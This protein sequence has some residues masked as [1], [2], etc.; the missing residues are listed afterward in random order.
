MKLTVTTLALFLGISAFAGAGP[1]AGGDEFADSVRPFL[2][3]YC[4]SC[5][6]GERPKGGLS[7]SAHASLADAA[8]DPGVWRR[9]HDMMVREEMPP[10][11]EDQPSAEE[12]SRLLTWIDAEFPRGNASRDP[13]RVTMRRL[14]RV[15]YE[16]TVRD[17]VGVHFDASA[18]FPVDDV[19]HG[20]DNIADVLSMSP[21]LLEKYL[22]AAERIAAL[23]IVDRN[24]DQPPVRIWDGEELT[25]D[26]R[27]GGA[28]RGV[29][30]LSSNGE[31]HTQH[32]F[33][34][35][36]LY[37]LRARAYGQQAGPA[38]VR[39]EFRID[40]KRQKVVEVPAT[41]EAPGEYETEVR[42]KAGMHRV[43]VA[44]IN[45]YYRPEDPD[46]KNRDRNFALIT[47]EV[48][49]PLDPA[50]LSPFQR[51]LLGDEPTTG[52]RQ[53]KLKRAVESLAERAYRRPVEDEE[54]ERLL[55]AIDG[56][57]DDE[58]SLEEHAR[59]ALTMLLV[60][61]RFLF[62]MELDPSGGSAETTSKVRELDGYELASRLSY[63]LWSSMPDDA[64]FEAAR[65]GTLTGDAELRRQVRRMIRSP[66]AT[67]L[68]EN[69]A[70][71]WLQIRDLVDR[72]PDPK[73]FP[74]VDAE[75]LRS[76]VAETVLL[77]EAVL[78]EGRSVRELLDADFT[79]V[80]EKL[81]RHYG[82]TPVRGA[83]MR[84]VAAV[85]PVGGGVLTHGSI[86]TA[87]SNPTR[88]SPVKRGKWILEALLDSAPP[89]PP[90]GVESLDESDKVAEGA[91]LRTMMEQHRRDPDCAVCHE[92]MDALGFG[93][94]NFD[95][96]GR[97]RERI[98]GS[99]VDATGTLPS[100]ETFDGAAGLKAILLDD[101]AFL[102]SLAKQLL[103]YALGRGVG[104][105]EEGTLEVLVAALEE[106]PT[107]ERL[108]TE[109]VTL[110]VFRKVRRDGT[111]TRVGRF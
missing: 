38:V 48:V 20:F 24:P 87:T 56:A 22:D 80:D 85:G 52:D 111:T 67:A 103:T 66:R 42:V 106:E 81:S 97:W 31:A 39:M 33:P 19:G 96:V 17:L 104:L 12:L 8:A 84:R 15:E 61:P 89:P 41:R 21:I 73:R 46:P 79:F 49:G 102:R 50:P 9:V 70:T 100:G 43:G 99:P 45:D 30:R 63:F 98:A 77:F 93:L 101:R 65:R 23:A 90:P 2:D 59:V 60:A 109:I 44:F 11:G 5:H 1:R 88:T 51:R 34:R 86:L 78:R 7:L 76:M 18:A 13:G 95:A 6:G 94:E 14:N 55:A 91:D 54:L 68:A 10:L 16:N 92:R 3:R 27:I 110:D 35:D 74:D 28:S 75:L 69:F 58:A 64:L 36:G 62:R 4:T 82:M 29:R 37:K 25:A 26:T 105:D 32:R 72:T 57:T 71:Q 53:P 108:I 40:R 83:H 107:L 47:F